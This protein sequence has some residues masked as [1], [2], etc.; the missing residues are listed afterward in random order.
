MSKVP[1]EPNE[2]GYQTFELNQDE[3]E[4][5]SQPVSQAGSWQ[6][7]T[8]HEDKAALTKASLPALNDP[9]VRRQLSKQKQHHPWF[10]GV[11]TVIQV[12][13]LGAEFYFNFTNTG[14]LIQTTPT[15]NYMI[16]PTPGILT[17]FAGR[18]IPC[19]KSTGYDKAGS[20]FI[21][22]SG[23]K[24]VNGTCSLADTCSWVFPFDQSNPNQWFRFILPIFVHAGIV[25]LLL[26]MSFQINI[27]FQL[28]RE[29]GWWRMCLIYMISGAGGFIF[30]A[31]LSDINSTSV[32]ASGSLYG[33]DILTQVIK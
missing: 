6:D 15:F 26:N 30:G 28:E 9:V 12:L 21:C 18:F 5:Y 2:A 31:P 13:I 8:E 14:S 22:M 1:I 19:M 3:Y 20:R 29:I 11:V 4:F 10:L 17:M 32:G 25:H 24:G 23:I 33:N 7:L 27:G 16:G